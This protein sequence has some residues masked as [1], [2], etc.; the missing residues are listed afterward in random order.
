MLTYYMVVIRILKFRT[1]Y[2][3]K[4]RKQTGIVNMQKK[5]CIHLY[6][7]NIHTLV[8]TFLN[9]P[10]QIFLALSF[11]SWQKNETKK[12]RAKN[13]PRSLPN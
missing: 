9:C 10:P 13:R 7:K 2:T 12:P 4:T 11:F 8:L 3:C 6:I 5:H 1:H